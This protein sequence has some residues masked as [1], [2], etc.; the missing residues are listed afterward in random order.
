MGSRGAG[1]AMVGEVVDSTLHEPGA[2]GSVR[3]GQAPVPGN[4]SL[5]HIVRLEV[6]GDVQ[7][8]GDLTKE[9]VYETHSSEKII[10]EAV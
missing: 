2:R 10:H 8:G 1:S 4:R 6:P 9:L 3:W 5:G 7:L